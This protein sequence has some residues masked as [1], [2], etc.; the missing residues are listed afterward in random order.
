MNLWLDICK[1]SGD[2]CCTLFLSIDSVT[3]YL[4]LLQVFPD[5]LE[6]S[7]IGDTLVAVVVIVVFLVNGEYRFGDAVVSEDHRVPTLG[8]LVLH[9]VS[10]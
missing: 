5:F 10:C 9:K 3:N 7:R 4:N 8:N 2:V 1:G 6:T